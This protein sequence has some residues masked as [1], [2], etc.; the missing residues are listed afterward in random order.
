MSAFSPVLSIQSFIS[1][2]IKLLSSF[3]VELFTTVL[4]SVLLT[5]V[6]FFIHKLK[7]MPFPLDRVSVNFLYE[8]P[9]GRLFL[10]EEG[11]TFWT[12]FLNPYKSR[13]NQKHSIIQH[14]NQVFSNRS[15]QNRSSIKNENTKQNTNQISL[16]QLKHD[17]INRIPYAKLYKGLLLQGYC[18]SPKFLLQLDNFEIRD[19]DVFIVSYPRSG[20]TWTE[21]LV[22]SIYSQDNL[23]SLKD[24][25]IHERVIHLEV[26]R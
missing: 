21:E 11:S 2:T 15:S 1:D 4:S 24:K 8:N 14:A 18:V 20:T 23:D 10:T 3:Q 26:G 7:S 25:L 17:Y 12:F 9:I 16:E 6:M 13:F 19:D 22:S 5:G